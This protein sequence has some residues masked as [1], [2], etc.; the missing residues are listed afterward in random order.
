MVWPVD[1]V[2]PVVYAWVDSVALKE[3]FVTKLRDVVIPFRNYENANRFMQTRNLEAPPLCPLALLS[4]VD[5]EVSL[6]L[7][8]LQ[9]RDYIYYSKADI[10]NFQPLRHCHTPLFLPQHR[11]P[12]RCQ[13]LCRTPAPTLNHFAILVMY[14][15]QYGVQAPS[16]TVGLGGDWASKSNVTMVSLSIQKM[17]QPVQET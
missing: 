7:V 6:D 15:S 9:Y 8:F 17:H 10:C 16:R 4:N 2:G 13:N 14:S 11:Q 1:G 12:I 3:S 5:P